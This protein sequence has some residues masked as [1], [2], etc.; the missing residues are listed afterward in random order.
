MPASVLNR[1]TRDDL[2]RAINDLDAGASHSY[3][4]SL[5]YDVVHEGKRYPPKAVVGLAARYAGGRAP[6]PKEFA[7][8]QNSLAFKVLEKHGFEIVRK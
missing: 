1:I 8:G 3:G 6:D 2:L 4:R 5:N 7:G